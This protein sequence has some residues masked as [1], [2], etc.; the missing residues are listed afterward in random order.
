MRDYRNL[1]SQALANFES[2]LNLYQIEWQKLS[3]YEYDL[4]NPNR[5]D[6]NF[7]SCRFNVLKNIGSDFALPEFT[8]TDYS[9]LGSNFSK[10]DYAPITADKQELRSGYDI[11][12]LVQRIYLLSSYGEAADLLTKHLVMV[13]NKEGLKDAELAERL[14]NEKLTAHR[15]FMIN[16]GIQVWDLCQ[17][18]RG[19]IGENYLK[20]RCIDQAVFEDNIKFHP[21]V[22]NKEKGIYLPCLI[23][24]VSVEP[25]G[26]LIALHRI[27]L[28]PTGH[29]K[30]DVTDPKMSMGSIKGGGIWLGKPGPKLYIAEGPENALSLRHSDCEFVV[31]T[32]SAS[33]FG[34][35]TIPDYVEYL[36]L[37][38]DADEAGKKATEKAA[39]NYF[40]NQKKIFKTINPKAGEDWNSLLM[41]IKGAKNG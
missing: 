4:K 24:K 27:Y 8:Q 16:R 22:K 33:N 2:L 10:E 17:T 40:F 6:K 26:P 36:V 38:P 31:S 37:A 20:N 18:V 14:R 1:R 15:L 7:G 39:N 3:E 30:A 21:K 29:R 25:N 28:D 11:I 32:M 5:N 35:L 41:Q 19:T 9:F 12:G 23:F 34:N 13:A